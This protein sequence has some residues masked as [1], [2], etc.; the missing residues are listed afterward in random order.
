M[1]STFF[2][3]GRRLRSRHRN[4][5]KLH[6]GALSEYISC[7]IVKKIRSIVKKIIATVVFFMF[8]AASTADSLQPKLENHFNANFSIDAAHTTDGT[9][10][11]VSA[12]GDA[13]PYGRVYLSYEFTDKQDLGDRGEFTGHAWGQNGEEVFTATLQGVYVKQGVE[14]KMYTLDA[15]SN[16]KFTYAVGTLNFVEKTLSFEAAD[17]IVD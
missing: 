14:F 3:E 4:R 12:S 9:N 17:L 11:Q 6:F 13:G 8:S 10:Y 1:G 5:T 2:A 16:G 7:L 15:V